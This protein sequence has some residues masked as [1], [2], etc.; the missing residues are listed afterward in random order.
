M[1]KI[2]VLALSL[3][4]LVGCDYLD[5]DETTGR[6]QEEAYA[7]F[8][9]I[10]MLVNNV[11]SYLPVDLGVVSDAMMESATDN[12]VYVWE[13]N[14]IN[15]ISNGVWSPL[16]TVNDGWNLWDGIR[17]ANL[18]LENFSL[19]QLERFEYNSDYEE[20]MKRASIYPYEVRFLRAFYMFE[21]AKRY[22]DIPLL[23]ESCTIDEANNLK[24]SSFIDVINFIADECASIANELPVDH[25]DYMKETGR[26]TKGAALALRSRALLYAASPLFNPENLESRWE[27]AA[28]AAYDVISMNAYSLDYIENDPLYSDKGGNEILKSKQLIFERRATSMTNTFEAR[29][30][31][32]GYE[33]AKGGNTP[34]QNLVDAYE[35]KTSEPFD[36]NNPSHVSNMYYDVNGK[37]TRDPRL[38]LNV[39]TNGSEWLGKIIN[40]TEGGWN[41]TLDGSTQTG[42]YLRKYLSPSVSL[43]PD[44]P[45]KLY[46]HYILFRYAEI[47]LNYAE[48]MYE[49]KGSDAT[50]EDCKMTARA[51]LNKVRESAHMKGITE[52]GDEFKQKIRNERRIE[53]A[54]EGHR[55]FDLRRWKIAELEE[56]RNIYGVKITGSGSSLSYEKVL[57][58]QMYWD[59]NDKMYLFPFP[60]NETYLNTNLIQNPGWN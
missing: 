22:G 45:N 3:L 31:P 51:A 18:F 55:F 58:K 15:Y 19:E 6:T 35:M 53:L 59:D 50:T 57:L 20:N 37:E 40:T 16:K 41:K 25:N 21:L 49:W 13:N 27:A 29:N 28:K 5:Y 33:G 44:K 46:H 60:Q 36:W 8:D 24:K 34:T 1:K 42:Y 43:D 14:S 56:Y 47:L 30:E 39:L 10:N 48:A 7:Y 11:Y 9:N 26:V 54:F 12:S 17:S 38:Y 23:K 2:Y 32:M 52:V 4:P